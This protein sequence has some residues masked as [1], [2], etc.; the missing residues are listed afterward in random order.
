MGVCWMNWLPLFPPVL[1]THSC[2]RRFAWSAHPQL[3]TA[4]SFLLFR[5]QLTYSPQSSPLSTWPLLA[6]SSYLNSV[7]D[8]MSSALTVP[9]TN[10]SWLLSWGPLQLNKYLWR[11]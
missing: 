8:F 2:L 11:E 3:C 1:Q 9:F 6:A 7:H 4:G 10:T 5:S